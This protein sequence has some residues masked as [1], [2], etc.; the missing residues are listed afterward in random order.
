MQYEY[1]KHIIT[2]KRGTILPFY[3]SDV[4]E[5]L[6]G[7]NA[8]RLLPGLVEGPYEKPQQSRTVRK[9]EAD[10][11][12]RT[13]QR[14]IGAVEQDALQ[15]LIREGLERCAGAGCAASENGAERL[16]HLLRWAVQTLRRLAGGCLS[17]ASDVD[18][19][20]RHG[21]RLLFVLACADSVAVRRAGATA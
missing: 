9:L 19:R 1:L 20:Q 7:G 6:P 14:Q 5:T 12:A 8:K 3:L 16:S 17:L 21:K 10:D 15:N 11:Q 13:R 18:G 4:E 2:L